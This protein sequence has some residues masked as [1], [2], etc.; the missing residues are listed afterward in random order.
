MIGDLGHEVVA[1]AGDLAEA[2]AQARNLQI[3]FAILDVNLDGQ[4]TFPVASELT[5][6]SIAGDCLHRAVHPF[7]DFPFLVPDRPLMTKFSHKLFW[8]AKMELFGFGF[9]EGDFSDLFD[10]DFAV[11]P[12]AS[13]FNRQRQIG[14][15]HD[16]G[17][18]QPILRAG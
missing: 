17:F 6:Q 1:R 5:T 10:V 13:V 2:S 12:G 15:T 3:D 9:G 14:I 7:N 4:A 11:A 18:D 8:P 16:A